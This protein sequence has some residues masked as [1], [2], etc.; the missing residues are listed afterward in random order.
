MKTAVHVIRGLDP[1]A[2][3][4]SVSV[5]ALVEA[6]AGT[7]RY[8]QKLVY[9]GGPEDYEVAISQA[10]VVRLP[11]S[12]AGLRYGETGRV[13]S[14]I[15]SESDIV[16]IHGIWQAHCAAA[17]AICRRLGRPFLVSAHGMLEPWALRNKR[18]KKSPYSAVFERRNLR[19]AA[20]LRALTTGEIADYRR[21]GLRAPAAL[22]P[23]GVNLPPGIGPEPFYRDF[24]QLAGKRL[25]LFLSRVHYKKGVDILC[26]AWAAVAKDFPEA[27]L[28][29]AGPDFEGT[30][31]RVEALVHELGMDA[32]VTFAGMLD[33][34]AKWAALAASEF[35]V[36]PSHSEG[37]SMAILEAL[38]A[39]RPVIITPGCYFP[40]VAEAGCGIVTDPSDGMVASVL[41]AMLGCA[42]E[43]RAAMGAR[44]VQL[45]RSNFSWPIIGERMA[46]I[47]DW[48]LG[49]G[50]KPEGVF[51]A[52]ERNDLEV[53]C[54]A[55]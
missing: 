19:S 33:G 9:F 12:R 35:F 52:S 20:C 24:P 23:N 1:R 22:I 42:P 34:E 13:L 16:H 29:I 18:W 21:Y 41:R 55:S 14:Q 3:G 2:G 4:M 26:R 49:G 48:V 30:L 54:T 17:G 43:E 39:A 47:N 37:F 38:A 28:V 5:P 53:T 51:L 31:D 7:G 25:A 27:H 40:E 50:P 8:E 36:L 32:R 15:V 10:E 44:G 45:V 11:W 46:S 6:I